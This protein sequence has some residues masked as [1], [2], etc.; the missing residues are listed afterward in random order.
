MPIHRW[1]NKVWY[2]HTAECCL[3]IQ[4]NE[5]SMHRWP[6]WALKTRFWVKRS[7]SQHYSCCRILFGW[8]SR[9]GESTGMK[10]RWIVAGG[11]EV[12]ET[13]MT[14]WPWVS[15]RGDENVLWLTVV[16]APN[17]LETI[18][19]HAVAGGIE[20]GMFPRKAAIFRNEQLLHDMAIC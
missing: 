8:K 4:R 9:R 13:R 6:G 3:A 1:I 14:D 18:E 15:F 20:W 19:L 2:V 5:I 11:W 12:R 7:Q 17:I 16:M 10:S